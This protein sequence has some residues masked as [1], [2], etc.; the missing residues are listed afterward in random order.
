MTRRRSVTTRLRAS[1][2]GLPDFRRLWAAQTV[3]TVGDQVFPIAATIAVLDA[4]GGATQIGIVL[5]ARV[6]AIVLFALL[7]G[8]WADR[9][10]RRSVMLA[11]NVFRGVVLTALTL[12]PT[13][14]PVPVLALLV[15]LVGAGEAF[16]RP[17]EAALLPTLVPEPRRNSANGLVMVSFRTAA[18]IG[19]GLAGVLVEL[20]GVRA[21]FALNAVTFAVSTVFLYA[22]HEPARAHVEEPRQPMVREIGEGVREVVRRRWVAANMVAATLILLLVVAPEQVLL[23]VIS[24]QEFGNDRVYVASLAL[25]SLGGVFGALLAMRWRPRHPGRASWL[26][27]LVYLLAILAL[28]YPAAAWP[29]LLTFFVSG[30]AFEPFMVFWSTALQ[31]EIPQDRL[32]RV[33]SLDWMAS[34]AL[35]PLGLAVAGPLADLVGQNVVLAG[36][37]VSLVLITVGV[38]RVPGVRDFRTPAEV[39]VV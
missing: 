32:A 28:M 26:L 13:T 17:A 7:G 22:L 33:V 21:A 39:P 19:P 9:L 4:G 8:V 30:V 29:I 18:V 15:F 10:P 20:V 36:A 24:R 11:A 3:S 27:G 6:A 34:F 16:F 35:M 12:L 38:L 31:R 37:G 1:V 14:P 23:P 25:M 5:G 2:L